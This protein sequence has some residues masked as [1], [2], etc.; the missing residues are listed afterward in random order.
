[1]SAPLAI[2][3]SMKSAG[4]W[5]AARWPACAGP[6]DH[7]AGSNR[8]WVACL[9]LACPGPARRPACDGARTAPF[10]H[11]RRLAL[12]PGHDVDLIDLHGTLQP[13][14]WGF[15]DEAAAQML[16]HGLHVR[17]V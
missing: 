2:V 3:A 1:M 10:G 6:P 14:C 4:S 16:R 11:G 5:S 13:C 8:G 17:G 15:G 9:S 12:V 7:R